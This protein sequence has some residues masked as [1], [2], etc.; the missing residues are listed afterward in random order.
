MLK[1]KILFGGLLALTIALAAAC[2]TEVNVNTNTAVD[3]H[4]GHSMNQ[5]AAPAG[6]HD[7]SDMKHDMSNMGPMVSAPG[8]ADQPYDLQF[9][10]SMVHHHEG[11]VMMSKMA[12][13]KTENT[14]LRPF[15]QKIIDDQDKEIARMKEWRDKW[16]SGKPSAL[17]MEM[18][19]MKMGSEKMGM[20][21]H[22]K[23][24]QAMAGK[25]FDLHFI[26]MMIPHHEGAIVMAKD[27]LQKAEHAEIKTLSNEVIREQE[28]E[29]KQMRDWKE[30]WSK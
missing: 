7:M 29:I 12:L 24:M 17:N 13:E 10:D 4:A 18:P 22:E 2:Q 11:A 26:D 23:E 14:E 19:G 16:Y 25:D 27:A 30:K 1:T 5:N 3:P 20:S 15:L 28:A 8:A 9:I 6:N 21:S